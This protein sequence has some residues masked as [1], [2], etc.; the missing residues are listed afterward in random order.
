MLCVSGVWSH[1][2]K[3]VC[4]STS[5]FLP[6][7]LH[8]KCLCLHLTQLNPIESLSTCVIINYLQLI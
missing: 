2:C 1:V 7:C 5:L 6:T 3:Y 4:V 8:I